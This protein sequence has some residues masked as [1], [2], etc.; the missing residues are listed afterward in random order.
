L[1]KEG[2]RGDFD[3][4]GVE[5]RGVPRQSRKAG[6]GGGERG[7]SSL[8]LDPGEAKEE[9]ALGNPRPSEE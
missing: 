7:V 1:F 4:Q 2:F 8:T 5:G 9:R 6:E 3:V